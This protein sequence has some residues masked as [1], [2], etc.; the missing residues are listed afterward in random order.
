MAGVRQAGFNACIP[1]IWASGD[2]GRRTPTSLFSS[3]LARMSFLKGLSGAQ[4]IQ[5]R[6]VQCAEAHVPGALP[7]R[8]KLIENRLWCHHLSP[9]AR[10]Q[11]NLLQLSFG[12]QIALKWGCKLSD[13]FR[14][15]THVELQVPPFAAPTYLRRAQGQFSEQINDL[16]GPVWLSGFGQRLLLNQNCSIVVILVKCCH[17]GL[18]TWTKLAMDAGCPLD[19]YDEPEFCCPFFRDR[20]A[21]KT[22]WPHGAQFFSARVEP[23]VLIS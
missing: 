18:K 3:P 8:V 13:Q 23:P 21:L 22:S 5:I 14:W 7:R 19:P 11:S 10:M 2:G 16:L 17:T 9:F 15:S 4:L 1:T 12:L 20:I 6:R